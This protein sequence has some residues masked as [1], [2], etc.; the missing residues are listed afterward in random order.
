MH[1]DCRV[2][3]DFTRATKAGEHRRPFSV[4]VWNSRG[5]AAPDRHFFRDLIQA[6]APITPTPV[7]TRPIVAGSGTVETGPPA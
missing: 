6:I 1:R 3:E 4:G 5:D 7:A 2:F